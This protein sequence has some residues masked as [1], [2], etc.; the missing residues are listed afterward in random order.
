MP[1][2]EP[3]IPHLSQPLICVVGPTASGKSDLAQE[4]ARRLGG[5]VI[6]ADSMQVYR[7]MDIGTGKLP[8]RRRT[9]D[10]Y[11]LDLVDPGQAYSVALYQ[12]YARRTAAALDAAGIRPVLC[13][14]TGLYVR[15]VIDGYTYP[16]GGA[17]ENPVRTRYEELLG[18]IGPQALWERLAAVD[19]DSAALIH[20]NNSRRVIRAFE[21][22]AQGESYARQRARLAHIPQVV[23]AVQIGLA[24]DPAA[25]N[26]RIDAR[27]DRMLDDGLVSEV[28]RLLDAGLRGALTAPQAIGYKEI[29]AA[30][31]GECTRAQAVEQIKIATH[32]Y[33]KRQRSWFRRDARIHWIDAARS[34]EPSGLPA[35]GR[36]GTM[37]TGEAPSRSAAPATAAAEP[38]DNGETSGMGALVQKALDVLATIEG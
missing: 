3:F 21:L 34:G 23:P 35:G 25:L 11:G 38:G 6:S 9:V 18:R 28:A 2:D 13:G 36:A 37:L 26:A 19:P 8:A 12:D 10:H 7:G 29:V 14:G 24:V 16:K 31:E 30:L 5:A 22:A 32:R 20:P 1:H 33:A 27:V 17:E 15:A 4:L